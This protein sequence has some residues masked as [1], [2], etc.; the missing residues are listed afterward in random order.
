M[1]T[2]GKQN[3]LTQGVEASIKLGFGVI[4]LLPGAKKPAISDWPKHATKDLKVAGRYFAKH[5]NHNYGI[6]TG[7]ASGM[8]VLDVDGAEG[9]IELAVLE[10]INGALPRT[11]KVKTPNGEHLYFRTG[12]E[13]VPNSVGKIAAHIDVRGDRGYV[14]VPGT[15]SGQTS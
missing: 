11:V 14:D 12:N 6:P 7:A 1:E 2:N 10:N 15:S 8:F 13:V 5:H 3:A 4:P 9:K